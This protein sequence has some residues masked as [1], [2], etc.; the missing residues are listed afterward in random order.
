MDIAGKTVWIT[1]ASSGIGEQLAY[2]FDRAGANLMLSARREDELHRVA[3]ACAGDPIVARLDLADPEGIPGI[4][5][6]VLTQS[7]GI[8]VLINNAGVTHR[9]LA[10][11]TDMEV[12][13]TIMEVNHF[14]PLALSKAV[15]P[16]MAERGGG[17][18]VAVSSIAGR[19]SSPYRS[20]YNAAKRALEGQMEAL[21]AELAP[22][23]IGVTLVV[24]GAIR[25]EVSRTALTADGSAYG[26]V[27]PFLAQGVDPGA[28]AEMIL[29][30]VRQDR[31]EITIARLKHRWLVWRR[32]FFPKLAARAVALK[33]ASSRPALDG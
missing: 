22:E 32:R 2:A 17:R 25:T 19:Y 23:N 6:A 21:R 13:R 16:L 20:G 28:T 1:G 26:R 4:A 31:D 5:Q 18:I 9:A 11:T 14:G 12:F 10:A 27:D 3:A 15:I 7:D 24:L 8:D 33:S 30:A 29:Q